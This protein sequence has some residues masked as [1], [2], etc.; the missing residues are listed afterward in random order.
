MERS[1][2]ILDEDQD[3]CNLLEEVYSQAEYDVT[4]G[5]LKSDIGKDLARI[6][7]SIVVIDFK[8][9]NY[10]GVDLVRIVHNHSPESKVIVA[11]AP[12]PEQTIRGMIM[13]EIDGLFT[14]P[15]KPISF[16]KRS[17]E[18]LVE[19]NELAD[20][21]VDATNV[22]SESNA[23][24][25]KANSIPGR[26]LAAKRFLEKLVHV[27]EFKSR[28]LLVG[29]EG[30]PF[31]AV[32]KDLIGALGKNTEALSYFEAYGLSVEALESQAL[33]LKKEGFTRLTVAMLDGEK[34]TDED[35]RVIREIQAP[36]G[37]SEKWAFP[38]RFVFCIRTELDT[39]YDRQE[40]STSVYMTLGATELVIPSLNECAE[41]IPQIA[42]KMIRD[43]VTS[44][45]L[46]T[47]PILEGSAKEYLR[48]YPWENG[49]DEMEV[50]LQSVIVKGNHTRITEKHF[51]EDA[52][53]SNIE[54]EAV[55][56]LR[57]HLVT[58]RDEYIQAVLKMS[59]GDIE[60]ASAS[61][62][63]DIDGIKRFLAQH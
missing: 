33:Q 4:I 48:N 40:I 20:A 43:F 49:F 47:M 46:D 18:L 2:L 55:S 12:L 13:E 52:T 41:D 39:L 51:T 19:K 9:G 32:S 58:Q 62:G 42:Q 38:I 36:Q 6:K 14:K 29:D 11:S 44:N 25:F 5:D 37:Y 59:G 16:L 3:Y 15:L 10:R 28:L 63:I 35:V 27:R 57:K 23:E 56:P 17:S 34:L 8:F 50:L 60:K 7:P 21:Q 22:Q 1:V 31:R 45:G 61:L 30:S 24:T 53:E 26:S 54:E